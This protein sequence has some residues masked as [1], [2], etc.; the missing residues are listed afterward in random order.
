[1]GVARGLQFRNSVTGGG[2]GAAKG[3][4]HFFEG[5]RTAKASELAADALRQGFTAQKATAGPLKFIDGNGVVRLTLKQGSNRT[6]GS[7]FAHA[8]FRNAAGQRVDAFGSA[9]TRTS[10]GNHTPI[11][12]DFLP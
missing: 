2:T 4:G 6:P 8:E 3:F 10:P 11:D 9:V 1:M 7:N 12:F 5:G